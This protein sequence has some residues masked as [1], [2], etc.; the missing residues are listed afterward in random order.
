VFVG[1]GRNSAAKATHEARLNPEPIPEDAVRLH[2]DKVVSSRPFANAARSSRFLRFVVEARLANQPNRIQEYVLGLEVFD[3]KESFD[4]RID[5]IVRVEGRRLRL[6]LA[7]YYRR[8]GRTDRVRIELPKRGYVPDSRVAPS[9]KGPGRRLWPVAGV[10]AILLAGGL[11]LL[12]PGRRSRD[13]RRAPGPHP[14]A[15]GVLPFSNLSGD[16]GQEYLADGMTDALITELAKLR[17]VPVISRTSM[18]RYK[19]SHQSAPAIARELGARY[20]LEG[21]VSRSGSRVRL[22]VQLIDADTDAHVWA[23]SYDREIAG[24][25]LLES[26]LVRR[27][28]REIRV[29]LTPDADRSLS[30]APVVQVDALDAYLKGKFALQ[31]WTGE[32]ARRSVDFLEEALRRD[33][34]FA[35]AHAW[36][37]VAYRTETAMGNTSPEEMLPLAT[38]EARK[39]VALAPQSSEAHSSL[40]AS[41]AMHTTTPYPSCTRS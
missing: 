18:M 37:A 13:N 14:G 19:G 15:I 36:L 39:A 33:P 17:S 35:L 2:L 3:R 12:L 10:L 20:L 30:E 21:A 9:G 34:G 24:V 1:W 6:R 25:F 8:Q 40:A 11:T 4:P 22:T 16:P 27:I 31:Q 7:E 28:A 26:E 41:L 23:Q 38:A 32:S 29:E 5:S